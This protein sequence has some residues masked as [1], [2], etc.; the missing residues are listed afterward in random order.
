MVEFNTPNSGSGFR[1]GLRI[2]PEVLTPGG[3]TRVQRSRHLSLNE[4]RL[5][6][7]PTLL[8]VGCSPA[9][10]AAELKYLLGNSNTKLKAKAKLGP[11][12]GS[13]STLGSTSDGPKIY[14]EQAKARARVELDIILSNDTC[15][16]GG[17]L[18]GQVNL[19][20]RK[21]SKK[22]API[23][24]SD[25][26]LRIVGFECIQNR[27]GRHIFYQYA[28]ALNA[29]APA[30]SPIYVSGPDTEGY[31]EAK[32]GLH[33]VPFAVTLPIESEYGSPKGVLTLPSGVA[34]RYIVMR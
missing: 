28:V 21:R 9:T 34:V 33:R 29:V 10:N 24:L 31:M 3:G 11:S 25:V 6:R 16:Q 12:P 4:G 20:I 32:E 7:Q 13:A 2:A 26:K 15:V 8:S 19:C 22:E 1:E 30:L 27:D 17:V 5:T 14:L 23:L 18:K